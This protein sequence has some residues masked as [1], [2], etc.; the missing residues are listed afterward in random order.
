MIIYVVVI[1]DGILVVFFVFWWLRYTYDESMF[2]GQLSA[3]LK[4]EGRASC[5]STW[6]ATHSTNLACVE[7]REQPQ[8]TGVMKP[9][10]VY[11]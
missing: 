6:S 2:C 11:S 10:T 3:T 4:S 9:E 1:N 7:K 8:Q 5:L